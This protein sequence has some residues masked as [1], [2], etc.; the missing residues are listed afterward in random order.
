MR[1]FTNPAGATLRYTDNGDGVALLALHGAYSTHGEIAGAL[2]PILAP[3]EAYRRIYPDLTGMGD[4]PAH[5]SIQTTNDMVSLVEDLVDEVVGA[6]PLLV[7]GHSYGGH[8]ARALAAH[9][10]QQVAGL[11]LICPMLPNAMHPEPHV[12]VTAESA[13][14]DLVD[15]TLR[16]DYASYF[17]VHTPATARRFNEAVAPSI[18]WFE[19]DPVARIMEAWAV[20]P[21]PDSTLFDKPTLIVTGRRDSITG[22]RGPMA[23]A[24]EYP[25]ATFVVLADTGHALPHERP[26]VLGALIND[27]LAT[28]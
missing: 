25:R 4:S 8:I 2:E 15:S 9:R 5:E 13:A 10:P 6:A 16:D 17:V 11:A 27:W 26:D 3:S 24:D 19:A 21:D 23:L 7:V 12:V 1:T 20:D 14:I 18:G 28:I 22:Y